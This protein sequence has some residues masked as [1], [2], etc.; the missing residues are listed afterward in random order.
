MKT[1]DEFI[2]K[3]SKRPFIYGET[4]CCSTVDR[5]VTLLT[6][7]SAIKT[8]GKIPS[9]KWLESEG[10]IK[11]SLKVIKR[12]PLVKKVKN[13]KKGDFAI[14]LLP[15]GL[16]GFAIKSETFWFLRHETGIIGAPT[17]TKILRA[18]TCQN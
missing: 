3:E 1:L 8:Y 14:I 5:W 15:S 9:K 2:R 12:F 18:W 7:Q 17:N 6:G 16:C 10:L 13:P 11:A 4:D